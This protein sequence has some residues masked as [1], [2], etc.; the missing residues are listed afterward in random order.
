M[1]RLI[2]A[3]LLLLLPA[4]AFA[5]DNAV[6]VTPGASASPSPTPSAGG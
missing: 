3:G 2:L 1:K 4:A 5:A 6:T